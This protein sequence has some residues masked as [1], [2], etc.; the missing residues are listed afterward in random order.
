MPTSTT[1]PRSSLSGIA[2]DRVAADY[3]GRRLDRESDAELV[4][5]AAATLSTPRR[6]P[7]DSFVLH[8][9]LELAA[10]AGLLPHV[11]PEAR[12]RARLRIVALSAGY[13]RYEPID[14]DPTPEPV[15]I[16]DADPIDELVRSIAGGDIAAA[17]HTAQVVAGSVSAGTAVDG[18]APSLISRTAAAGHAPIFFHH[19]L[20]RDSLS[21]VSLDLLPPLARE[22]AREPDWRISWTDGW[23][24]DH[25]TDASALAH[26][27]ATTPLLGRPEST[28]IHPLMMQ[29]DRP[30]VADSFLGPVLGRRTPAACREVLRTAARSML[31]DT[32]DHAPYGWTHCLTMPQALLAVTARSDHADLGFA[33]AA[34]EVG[35]FRAGLGETEI[36]TDDRSDGDPVD[37][38]ELATAAATSHD[39]HVVK[40]VLACLEAARDDPPAATLFL[41]A[42]RRLLDVWD[43][44]G[45]DPN[46]PLG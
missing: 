40:Y 25:A 31:H 42:G 46:D 45:G 35:A 24:P 37:V 13:E 26:A 6:D 8:A 39:A 41:S 30:G 19:L 12:E 36:P 27:L 44:N 34:T 20:R 32:P 28:S 43:A 11:A 23:S 17:G 2:I 22:I 1:P 7:A 15:A 21:G 3:H 4:R 9:P 33:L 5:S 29:V 38:R 14:V 10:R 16:D 18:L